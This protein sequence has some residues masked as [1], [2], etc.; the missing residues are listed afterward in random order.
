MKN[1]RVLNWILVITNIIIFIITI[2]LI[3]TKYFAVS[4]ENQWWTALAIIVAISTAS[5]GVGVTILL[6]EKD[7]KSELKSIEKR[8]VNSYNIIANI[9]NVQ[10]ASENESQEIWNNLVKNVESIDNTEI[11]KP[12]TLRTWSRMAWQQNYLDVA[13]KLR[14]KAFDLDPKDNSSRVM[15]C[16]ALTHKEKVDKTRIE[17]ILNHTVPQ[18]DSEL[19]HLNNIAGKYYSKVKDY[20]KVAECS[21]KSMTVNNTGWAFNSY[22]ECLIQNKKWETEKIKETINS[23]SDKSKWYT[24]T[25]LN[26]TPFRLMIESFFDNTKRQEFYDY[27]TVSTVNKIIHRYG[28]LFM[29]HKLFDFFNAVRERFNDE[30]SETVYLTYY[31]F[32][33]SY[34]EEADKKILEPKIIE[35]INSKIKTPYNTL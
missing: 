25:S 35:K 31:Y 1:N 20:D 33:G 19:A 24:S 7:F 32:M 22:V 27:F 26:Q 28:N 6:R 30:E 15:L 8:L 13:I 16:S 9:A 12:I 2:I 29:K 3:S 11:I 5:L 23:F 10:D 18:N 4:P 17:F 21:L 14:E 34:D